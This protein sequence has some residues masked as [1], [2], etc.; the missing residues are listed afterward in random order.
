[1]FTKEELAALY[2][3]ISER[4][5][6]NVNGQEAEVLVSLKKRIGEEHDNLLG[7]HLLTDEQEAREQERQAVDN[8]KEE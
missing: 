8:T 1:M 3:L 7:N 5:T 4:A 6:F 2:R